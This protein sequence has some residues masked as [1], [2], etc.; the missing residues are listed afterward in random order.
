MKGWYGNKMGHSLAS[1][2]VRTAVD[3]TRE[4]EH[5][6][7]AG[8]YEYYISYLDRIRAFDIEDFYKYEDKNGLVDGLNEDEWREKQLANRLLDYPEDANYSYNYEG[9]GWVE[10]VG[11]IYFDAKTHENAVKKAM[12]Y[13]FDA[14]DVY[15]ESG[16]RILSI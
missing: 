8:L 10:I 9:D 5:K 1:K 14:I 2:G 16:D 6:R 7:M 15:S 3:E 13:D 4:W 11:R 12:R